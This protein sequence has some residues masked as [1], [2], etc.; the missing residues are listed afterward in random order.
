MFMFQSFSLAAFIPE[1]IMVL[2]Y[3]FCLLGHT[4]TIEK[5]DVDRIE[6]KVAEAHFSSAIS[7][8]HFDQ[9]FI[10]ST[11]ITKQEPI[12]YPLI[13]SQSISGYRF[14]RLPDCWSFV[15]FSRPP[16]SFLI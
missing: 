4:K 13:A 8:Y 10:Q 16:P 6:P 2:A 14:C 1:I 7:A 5:D 12:V 3:V 11:E 15:Q 9:Q